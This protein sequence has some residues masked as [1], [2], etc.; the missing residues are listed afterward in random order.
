MLYA[1]LS[2]IHS[3]ATA[4]AR[5]LEEIDHHT[6]EPVDQIWCLGD[7]V[8]YGPDPNECIELLRDRNHLGIAGNHDWGIAGLA[9]LDHFSFAARL[10]AEWTRDQLTPDNL[11]YLQHLAT[12]LTVEDC[13]LVHGSPRDPIWEY[14]LSTDQADANFPLF[15]TRLCLVGH[16]HVPTIFLQAEERAD[17][18]MTPEGTPAVAGEAH[19][20][21]D[22]ETLLASC[23]LLEPGEGWWQV[24]PYCRAI[25]NPG[26]VGQPRDGDPRAAIAF[27]DPER[28]FNFRRLEYDI[29]AVQERILAAGLPRRLAERLA[30]GM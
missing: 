24:P 27:Y 23:D 7:I 25:I 9:S 15:A 11:A 18:E 17:S 5:A 16:T 22:E 4:L 12:T 3:N 10:V 2:D 19:A 21:E 29:V 6:D 30:Y 28:G 14:L 1:I 20:E 8:G 13:T 26:S